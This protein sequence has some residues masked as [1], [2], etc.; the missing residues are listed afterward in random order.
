MLSDFCPLQ[1]RQWLIGHIPRWH[2][3]MSGR[4]RPRRSSIVSNRRKNWNPT[5]KRYLS[6]LRKPTIAAAE[7]VQKKQRRAR[8]RSTASQPPRLQSAS[9]LRI[10]GGLTGVTEASTGEANTRR[11]AEPNTLT[12]TAGLW[13][14]SR[15][16]LV[17]NSIEES[18]KAARV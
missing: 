17:S 12:G 4:Y 5:T 7:K 6:R 8:W 10:T 14:H 15:G 1:F 16:V 2:D 11:G 18:T 3:R 9:L 13:L